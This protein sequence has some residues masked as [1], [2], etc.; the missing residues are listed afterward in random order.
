MLKCP[1]CGGNVIEE[2]KLFHCE[3]QKS[4]YKD[5]SWSEV[6]SCNFKVFKAALAKLG[7]EPVTE[8]LL[9]EIIENGEAQV[10]LTSKAGKPYTAYAVLD[11]KWGIKVDFNRPKED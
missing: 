7:G 11:D 1:K 8:D 6:G 5:N 3:N 4:E 9:A 10:D 2:E